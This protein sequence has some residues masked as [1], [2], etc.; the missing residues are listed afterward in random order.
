[1]PMGVLSTTVRLFLDVL[2]WLLIA[3]MLTS[4]FR[5]RY[6]TRSTSWFFRLDE[7]IWRATEPFL[8][9]IRNL[10]P[11]SG[12]GFDFTPMLLLLLIRWVGGALVRTLMGIGL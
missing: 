1:M 7:L 4:W 8:A 9:P 10:L 11:M 12:M 5:P 6:Q 3:R 2:V